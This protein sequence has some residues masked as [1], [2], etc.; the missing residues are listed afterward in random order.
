M[1]EEQLIKTIENSVYYLANYEKSQNRQDF[2]DWEERFQRETDKLLDVQFKVRKDTLKNFRGKQLFVIDHPHAAIKNFY[3]PHPLWYQSKR[4][5]NKVLGNQRGGIREAMD[6][7]DIIRNCGYLDLLKKY[8]NPDIGNPLSIHHKGY[9]FT[10]RYLR[11][12]YFLGLFNEHLREHIADDSVVLDLGCSYGIFSSLLKQEMSSTRHILVDLPGQLILAHYYLQTLFPKANI[13]G[14]KEVGE[15][16]KIDK[17]FIEQYDFILVPPSMY[18]T[19]SQSGVDL[20]TNFISLTEMSS[21]W[22]KKYIESEVFKTTPFIYMINRYDAHPTYQSETTILNYPLHEFETIYMRT[23][24]LIQ[25]FYLG[26]L[27]FFYKRKIYP[28]QFFQF[29]GRHKI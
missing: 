28:S 24:P 29:M 9:V 2:G 27:I 1:N 4:M 3:S 18:D 5:L 6:T 21:F 15:A 11:H 19:L 25:Y 23:C 14:F 17:S 12:I 7:F 26:F 13:A 8:P 10:Y 16:G 20:F 22:F